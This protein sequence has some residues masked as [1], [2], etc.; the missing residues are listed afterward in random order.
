MVVSGLVVWVPSVATSE[1]VSPASPV[2]LAVVLL[3]FAAV[4]GLVTEVM[5]T[6]G[7]AVSFVVVLLLVAVLLDE[8]VAVAV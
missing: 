1:I 6:T 7:A 4:M 2:P 8:S 3:A 5:A